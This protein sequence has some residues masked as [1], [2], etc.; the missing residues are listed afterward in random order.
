MREELPHLPDRHLV[1]DPTHDLERSQI[2]ER[3]QLHHGA[4]VQIVSHDHRDLVTEQRIHRRHATAQ[5]RVVDRVVVHEGCKVDQLDDGREADRPIVP[6]TDG[7][8]DEQQER[9]AK[10]LPLH[11]HQVAVHLGDQTEVGLE[12]AFDVLADLLEI[13]PDTSLQ[14]GEGNRL[15]GGDH[16]GPAVSRCIRSPTSRKRMSTART[17]S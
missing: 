1:G 12:K 6:F 14:L 2:T 16:C 10:H 9:R 4:G 8:I 15:G 5:H 17:R 3:D 11:P 13:P 7:V